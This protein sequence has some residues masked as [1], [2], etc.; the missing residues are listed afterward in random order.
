MMPGVLLDAEGYPSISPDDFFSGGALLPFGEYKG[1][2]D[3]RDGR[4]PGGRPFRRRAV[5]PLGQFVDYATRFAAVV[6]SSQPAPGSAG[7]LLPGDPA[8]EAR[9]QRGHTGIPLPA[10]TWQELRDLAAQLGLRI[11]EET[12]E[13]RA[14]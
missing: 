1:V 5:L 7:V 13:I 11:E 6:E 14:I 2:C 10:V 4:A 12:D 9:R 8:A 3:G